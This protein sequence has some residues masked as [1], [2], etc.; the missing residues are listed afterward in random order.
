MNKKPEYLMPKQVAELL[1]VSSNTIRQWTQQGLLK[2][3][4]TAGGHRRFYREEIERFIQERSQ[5]HKP[6]SLKKIRILI[7]DD[8][9]SFSL[10]LNELLSNSPKVDKI[11]VANS[12]F[13]AGVKINTFKPHVL[14]LDLIMPDLDGF[15]VCQQLKQ[16]P[17]TAA[18]RVIAMTGNHTEENV[19]RIISYGAETCLAKPF[20]SKEILNALG[21]G[22]LEVSKPD[23]AK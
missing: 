2:A 23:L 17:D 6:Q 9:T 16:S 11:E 1:M 7:V 5:S 12:G 4:I 20:K 3:E 19:Q 14:L 15:A 13:D 22:K 18:I 10:Y 21:F 8:D